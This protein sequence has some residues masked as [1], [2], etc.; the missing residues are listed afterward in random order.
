MSDQDSVVEPHRWTDV[1]VVHGPVVV[2]SDIARI[3]QAKDN[4][5][6]L[7]TSVE[8]WRGNQWVSQFI[9]EGDD[10]PGRQAVLKAPPAAPEILRRANVPA[11]PFP[12]GYRLWPEA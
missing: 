11:E 4:R 2:E 6:G 12:D 7:L 9:V 8:V 3:I 5:G 1:Y 10:Y